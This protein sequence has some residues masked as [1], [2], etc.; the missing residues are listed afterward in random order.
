MSIA[1][2]I[3][4]QLFFKMSEI[5]ELELY[6]INVNALCVYHC[7]NIFWHNNFDI[8]VSYS[9]KNNFQFVSNVYKIL[10]LQNKKEKLSA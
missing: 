3:F 10:L 6:C 2:L 7:N 8:K 4:D 9:A 1:S 5:F